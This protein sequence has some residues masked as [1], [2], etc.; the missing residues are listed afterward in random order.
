M[1]NQLHPR[2]WS[3]LCW[4]FFLFWLALG[5]LSNFPVGPSTIETLSKENLASELI[6]SGSTI[7]IESGWPNVY[8]TKN[9]TKLAVTNKVHF[10]ELLL[11]L[12]FV[13]VTLIFVVISLQFCMPKIP[14]RFFLLAIAIFAILINVGIALAKLPGT[15][16]NLPFA[17]F[18]LCPYCFPIVFGS[19]G[20]LTKLVRRKRAIA[21]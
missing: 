20:G 18:L 17:R 4:F 13:I 19:I 3:V 16:A 14:I 11:N 10:A 2:K 1:S 5:A 21:R 6:E 7:S 12:C 8:L 9:W 15:P